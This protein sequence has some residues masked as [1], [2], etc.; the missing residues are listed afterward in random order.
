MKNTFVFAFASFLSFSAFAASK[1]IKPCDATGMKYLNQSIADAKK[2]GFKNVKIMKNTKNQTLGFYAWKAADEIHAE[3][4]EYIDVEDSTVA[5][6]WYYWQSDM[7][8][9]PSS[10]KINGAYSI[11]QDEGV[12][13]LKMK[14]ENR[15]GNI[16]AVLEIE[17][18]DEGTVIRRELVKFVN[19]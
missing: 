13:T 16:E 15:S 10:W 7:N 14:K 9:N 1:T 8:A 19:L 3:I 18:V 4:C 2:D 5:N 6:T 17:G 12:A 11:A